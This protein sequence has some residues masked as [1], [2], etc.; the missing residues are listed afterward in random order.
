M[1]SLASRGAPVRR[2]IH[3][4]LRDVFDLARSRRTLQPD[5]AGIVHG[6]VGMIARYAW[7][8]WRQFVQMSSSAG[9]MWSVNGARAGSCPWVMSQRRGH[10]RIL[11]ARTR[12]CAQ[13]TYSNHTGRDPTSRTEREGALGGGGIRRLE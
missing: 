7:T 10:H 11:F 5:E 1:P 12:P 6:V 3:A 2:P 9:F 8:L 4:V 13:Y